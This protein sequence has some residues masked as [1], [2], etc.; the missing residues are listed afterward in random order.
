MGELPLCKIF[1]KSMQD[2]VVPVPDDLKITKIIP[3]YKL[4]DKTIMC[5][6]PFQKYLYLKD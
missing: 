4:D 2:G 6:Q 5:Y 1:N 3:V